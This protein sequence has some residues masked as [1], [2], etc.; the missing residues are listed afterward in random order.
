MQ[1]AIVATTRTLSTA[2]RRCLRCPQRS[3]ARTCIGLLPVTHS[4]PPSRT[5]AYAG[6]NPDTHEV[7]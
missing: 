7:D 6:I 5:D 2:T 3:A 4:P 1:P